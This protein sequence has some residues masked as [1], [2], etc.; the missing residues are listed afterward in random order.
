MIEKLLLPSISPV[1]VKSIKSAEISLSAESAELS[2]TP[3]VL[4]P[5]G[6]TES[7][8]P[9][10]GFQFLGSTFLVSRVVV[11]PVVGGF[12]TFDWLGSS[13]PVNLDFSIADSGFLDYHF[14]ELALTGVLIGLVVS[15]TDRG[16]GVTI[17][18]LVITVE[19]KG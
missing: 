18:L 17:R 6:F 10:G 11:A 13:D 2:S 15:A 16:V 4:V 3:I 12:A 1:L 7:L 19:G 5:E 9:S 14:C 8:V